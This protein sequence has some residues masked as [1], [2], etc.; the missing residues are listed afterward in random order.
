MANGLSLHVVAPHCKTLAAILHR[1]V[2][3]FA[4]VREHTILPL[5]STVPT[6]DILVVQLDSTIALEPRRLGPFLNGHEVW[7]AYS[8]GRISAR[9]LE[10]P[11]SP[12][13]HFVHCESLDHESGCR[14]L[15]TALEQYFLESEATNIVGLV[16]A[17]EPRLNAVQDLVRTI[18]EHPW[19]VRRPADLAAKTG[20]HLVHIKRAIASLD[21]KRVEHFITYV[22]WVAREQLVVVK[23]IQPAIAE[24]LTGIADR[25]NL[26]RQVARL[27][28]GSP[29]ALKRFVI[30]VV[31]A[32]LVLAEV[33]CREKAE[34]QTTVTERSEPDSA[35]AI[36]VAGDVVR[37]GDLSLSIRTT[38]QV[39]AERQVSLRAETQGTV[40]AVLARPGAHVDSGQTLVRL[41]PRP[42]DLAVREA[43]AQLADATVRYRDILL[44][45]DTTVSSPDALERRR[46]ARL[47]AGLD[48]AEA[49]VERARLDR[50][51][52]LLQ[53]PFAGTVD[54]V[55]A[56]VGQ[57]V[58]SGDLIIT[59]IDLR[60]LL[61]EAAVLEHDLSLIRPG[62]EAA[63]SL[64]AG[65][66]HSLAGRVIAVLP[67]VDTTT[68]AGRALVRVRT[69]D[70]GLRPG[71]FA[72][73]ELE[74]TRLPNRLLVPASAIIERDGRPLVFRFEAGRAKWVYVAP[75]RSNGRETEI[76]GDSLTGQ[77]GVSVGD[78]VLVEGHLTLTHDAPVRLSVRAL[79]RES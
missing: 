66:E 72:D 35:I 79:Q 61:V 67:L 51:R 77:A 38:G 74:T 73:V 62:A 20:K 59:L 43:E 68:R 11:H 71:M 29:H 64:S 76:L 78:T 10:M 8:E 4:R 63:V 30:G 70:A 23:R 27:R 3:R 31:L 26:R 5:C 24:H 32:L 12:N 44:G 48:G 45:D 57:R 21:F 41:D 60:S 7:L 36:P 2:G 6:G 56:V 1:H 40:L 75:G 14:A 9:W 19:Q 25:S 55:Q 39:R 53:A 69:V 16:T 42:F 46:N 33:A 15:A 17:N 22:R 28:A 50:E 18:C 58:G 34:G 49:R 52:A 47:R 65:G 13:V 54:Q 37:R